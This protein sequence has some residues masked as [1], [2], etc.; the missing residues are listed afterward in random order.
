[1]LVCSGL[2]DATVETLFADDKVS[3]FLHKPF[4]LRQL[5]EQVAACLPLRD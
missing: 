1:V 4:T 2:G 5:S 3:G